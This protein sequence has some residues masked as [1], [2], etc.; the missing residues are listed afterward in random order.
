MTTVHLPETGLAC[1]AALAELLRRRRVAVTRGAAEAAAPGAILVAPAPDGAA[2]RRL[3]ET[4]RGCAARM[5]VALRFGAARAEVT[6]DLGGR[7]LRVALAGPDPVTDGARVATD[8]VLLW[9]ADLVARPLR[10][11]VA[12]DAATGDL[13][14]LMTRVARTE[15]TVF[16][17]GPSGTGK[18][19]IA[20]AIHA[21]SRRADRPFI[22]LNC[23]AIPDNMLEAMLFGHEKG[24]FTGA[25]TAGRGLIRAAEGGTLM[26][27]EISEMPLGLQA[28]L[29]RVIQERTVTPLGATAE[30]PVDIR[31][32]ATSN[33]D[34]AAEIRAG[35]FREDLFYRLNVFPLATQPLA[36]RR[37]DIP[38]LAVALLS[39]HAEGPVPPL[40]APGALAA[41]MAHD[42]PGN[43]RE[44]ENVIQRALV[45]CEGDRIEAE[46][47]LIDAAP[48]PAM[49][50]PE[51]PGRPVLA[52]AV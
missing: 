6:T 47:I 17:N 26:L 34:M 4:A 18:E 7:L 39:R 50:L 45:L 8:P 16:V 29:L 10:P 21:A 11:M 33:R 23:A 30:Q 41:L 1:A 20:R 37:E 38:A 31:I 44:L 12:A 5:I 32:V 43:V 35:R 22:A 13:I 46:D 19:V 52:V 24:S 15:V 3:V 40:P 2:E 51:A 9:L 49:P 25:A 42:W 27:D 36:A 14:D 48:R 28:K